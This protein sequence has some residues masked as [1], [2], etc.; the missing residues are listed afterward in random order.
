MTRCLT[1]F[2]P[3]VSSDVLTRLWDLASQLWDEGN[4][5]GIEFCKAR[6][7]DTGRREDVGREKGRG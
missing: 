7:G 4:I 2:L 1:V 5:F 3:V 6:G